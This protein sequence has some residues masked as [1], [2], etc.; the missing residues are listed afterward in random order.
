VTVSPEQILFD[1]ALTVTPG[2]TVI[3]SAAVVAHCPAVGVNVKVVVA[4]LFKAGAQV[5]VIPLVDREGNAAMPPPEQIGPTGLKVGT[6]LGLIVMDMVAVVA[7][8][9]ATGVNVYTVVPTVVV[10]IVLG[11]HVPVIDGTLV[12]CVCKA[13]G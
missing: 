9:P 10:L 4:I 13:G 11:F 12:E 5:P 7:Q 1:E 8:N 6:M 2:F 3:V